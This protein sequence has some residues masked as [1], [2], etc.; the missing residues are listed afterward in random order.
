M[1]NWILIKNDDFEIK[2]RLTLSVFFL[3]NILYAVNTEYNSFHVETFYYF[4]PPPLQNEVLFFHPKI[5]SPLSFQSFYYRGCFC[6]RE[7]RQ[8]AQRQIP[9]RQIPQ[10]QILTFV[11]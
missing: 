1:L 2:P 8:I 7:A 9:Q 11:A 5:L 10:R 6:D 3:L 4:D